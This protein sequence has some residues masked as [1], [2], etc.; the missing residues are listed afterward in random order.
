MYK[1]IVVVTARAV[2]ITKLLIIEALKPITVVKP[3]ISRCIE[4]TCLSEAH[5]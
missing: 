4:Y 2:Y 5:V 1:S 3:S